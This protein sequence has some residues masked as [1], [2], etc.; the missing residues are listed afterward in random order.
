VPISAV[1]RLRLLM[2]FTERDINTQTVGLSTKISRSG[3]I[4]T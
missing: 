1:V 2:I 3:I 4:Q